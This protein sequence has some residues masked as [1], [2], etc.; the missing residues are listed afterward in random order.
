MYA[1]WPLIM[2]SLVVAMVVI[3]WAMV[4]RRGHAPARVTGWLPSTLAYVVAF[5]LVFIMQELALVLS[6]ALVPGLHPVLFHNNHD[7]TGDAPIAELLQGA[8]AL[9]I[10][11]IGL[12]ALAVTPRNAGVRLLA[13][14]IAFNGVVQGLAEFPAGAM[15]PGNDVG[16]AMRYLGFGPVTRGAAALAAIV[17]M[18]VLLRAVGRKLGACG[19]N[20]ATRIVTLALGTALVLPYRVPGSIDQVAIVPVAVAVIGAGW[21]VGD[22]AGDVASD[23]AGDVAPGDAWRG[24]APLAATAIAVLALFQL[25]LR[26]GIAF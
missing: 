5:N 8:G 21:I 14:W 25:V 26:H 7:W 19:I 24:A 16:R 1:E 15:I 10:I 12:T 18:I 3:P 2:V 13:A 20:R 17:G 11:V 23:G 6:K 9:T 22:G 4:A